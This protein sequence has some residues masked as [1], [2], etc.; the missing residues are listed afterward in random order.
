VIRNLR[1][2]YKIERQPICF[3][4][5]DAEV[6]PPPSASLEA[7]GVMA[8]GSLA[9]ICRGYRRL[10]PEPDQASFET[11]VITPCGW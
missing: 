2:Y 9:R 3:S 1:Y 7:L 10:D 8:D 6:I 11:A 4:R 5:D